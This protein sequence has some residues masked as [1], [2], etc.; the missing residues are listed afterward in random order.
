MANKKISELAA[1]SSLALADLLAVVQGGVT[2]KATLQQLADL[3]FPASYGSVFI[4]SAAATTLAAGV[5]AKVAGTTAFS[6]AISSPNFDDDSGV[7]NRLRYTGTVTRDFFVEICVSM[8]SGSNNQDLTF[9]LA[10]GGVIDAETK[11]FRKIGTGS[12]QGAMPLCGPVNLAQNEFVELWIENSQAN[13]VTVTA[14]VM[15]IERMH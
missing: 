11:I 10:K 7:S 2:L 13:A 12:D 8:T 5:P 14:M 1:V 9:Y 15:G 6:S 3:I 4:S